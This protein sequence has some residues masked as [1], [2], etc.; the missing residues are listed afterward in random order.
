MSVSVAFD[1]GRSGILLARAGTSRDSSD[2]W[3]STWAQEL[4]FRGVG[5]VVAEGF[6]KELVGGGEVLLAVT[7]QHAGTAVE[8]GPGRVGHQRGLAQTRLARDEQYLAPFALGDALDGIAYRLAISAFTPDHAHGGSN[9]QDGPAAGW[10]TRY[11]PLRGAP[12]PPRRSRPG[13]AVPSGSVPRASGIRGDCADRPWLEPHRRPGPVRSRRWHRAGPPRPPG[14][15]SSR[16]P[17]C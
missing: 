5:D 16:R 1:A 14:P 9:G 4:V 15:R 11:R 2:P 3:S 6:G 12:R 17:L 13:R 10:R 7:E 8:G